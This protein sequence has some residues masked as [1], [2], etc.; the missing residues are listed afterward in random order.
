MKVWIE[1]SSRSANELKGKSLFCKRL[2]D[3]FKRR[4]I[5]VVDSDVGADVSINVIRIK[6]KKSKKK[7]LR[8]DGVWHDTG[9]NWKSKNVSIATSVQRAD[10]VIYQSEFAR[11]MCEKYLGV[12][13]CPTKVIFNGSLPEIYDAITPA[14]FDKKNIFITFSKWRPHKRLRDTIHSFLKANIPD[15]KLLVM[16]GVER[17]GLSIKEAHR[18][19]SHKD[20]EY[21][22]MLPQSYLMPILKACVGSIHL[23]WFDACPNSVVEAICAKVP[24]I[25]NN[26]GGTWE[27]VAPSGG[28]ICNIDKP[29]NFE[30]VDLYDPPK[31]ELDV[32]AKN[33]RRCV[34]ERPIIKSEHVNIKNVAEQYLN[35]ISEIL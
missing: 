18:L 27:I 16:G 14:V 6:H 21:L 23:C 12:A 26:V 32:V 31:I 5:E 3:E 17:S 20:V 2:S 7:I 1:N 4:N 25:T 13:T 22:G 19:F 8:L 29:Y 33:M 24:V 34:K 28:Y 15:S 35:F 30:P 11:N 9:K 10:G